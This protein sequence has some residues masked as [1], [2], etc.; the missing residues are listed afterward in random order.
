MKTVIALML[1]AMGCAGRP[2]DLPNLDGAPSTVD[3]SPTP[4]DQSPAVVD[5][6]PAIVPDLGI[7]PACRLSGG[8]ECAYFGGTCPVGYCWYPVDMN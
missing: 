7:N 3:M 5:Q 2:V 1:F 6:S 4:A 8:L